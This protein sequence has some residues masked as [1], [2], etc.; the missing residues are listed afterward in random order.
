VSVLLH[1]ENDSSMMGTERR[2][3]MSDLHTL[4]DAILRRM[5]VC[6]VASVDFLKRFHDV[7]EEIDVCI[8]SLIAKKR[9]S[10]N[11][12]SVRYVEEGAHTPRFWP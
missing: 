7:P 6:G 4:E 1:K 3:T 12:N 10:K 9:I 11:G 5:R 2:C 8:E